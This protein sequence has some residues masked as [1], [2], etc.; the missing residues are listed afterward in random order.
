MRIK[1]QVGHVVGTATLVVLVVGMWS[2]MVVGTL[3]VYGPWG[4]KR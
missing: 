2:W 1:E 4:K 3:L